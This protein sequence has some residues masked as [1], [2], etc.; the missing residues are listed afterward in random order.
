MIESLAASMSVE[1]SRIEARHSTNREVTLLRARGWI[2]S[3][4]TLCATFICWT[5][6]RLCA[7]LRH[8]CTASMDAFG[9]EKASKPKKEKSRVKK[10]RRGGGGAWRCFLHVRARGTRF[11][12]ST[13]SQL[14]E[15][16]R[17][18]SGA[19]KQ[20]FVEAGR[21][22]TFAHRGGFASFG[23]R[24]QQ[25]DVRQRSSGQQL[26]QM[27]ARVDNV[28]LPGDVTATG[29]IVASTAAIEAARAVQYH[30]PG[31]FL[32]DY[33]DMADALQ[34]QRQAA[35]REEADALTEADESA[36]TALQETCQHEPLVKSINEAEHTLLGQGFLK[37]KTCLQA[38]TAFH[39]VPPIAQVAQAGAFS[40]HSCP[41]GPNAC[42]GAYADASESEGLQTQDVGHRTQYVWRMGF[43]MLRL[44]SVRCC[45]MNE[46]SMYSTPAPFVLSS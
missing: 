31:L 23:T 13:L 39:W 9:G 25:R 3:L 33:Q 32:Q 14:A 4:P 10:V 7:S 42:Y 34:T 8:V 18:L 28:P 30:G 36:L 20:R 41:S 16:Y 6:A 19:E 11:T 5:V 24:P 40:F 21:A 15:E 17:A 44:L 2:A 35:R 46:A 43:E 1:I 38:M 22:G 26:Q 37:V 29:A 45:L 27:H 12:V